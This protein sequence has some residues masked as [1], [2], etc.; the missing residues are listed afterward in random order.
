M[1]TEHLDALAASADL[2]I[3]LTELGTVGSAPVGELT[4]HLANAPIHR[5]TLVIPPGTNVGLRQSDAGPAYTTHSNALSP[6]NTDQGTV[7]TT[8]A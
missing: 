5:P 6:T 3:D 4:V 2:V 7:N 8:D 1:L